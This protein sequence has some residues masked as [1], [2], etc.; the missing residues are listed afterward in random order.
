MQRSEDIRNRRRI[1]ALAV[2]LF[3]PVLIACLTCIPAAAADPVCSVLPGGQAAAWVLADFDGDHKLDMAV[4]ELPGP[5]DSGIL[6]HITIHSGEAGPIP[7]CATG[8]TER[9]S[10]RD[11]DGDSDRD[12]VLE[13]ASAEPIAIWINDG[14][15]HFQRAEVADFRYQ[16]SHDDP[17]SLDSAAR[18]SPQPDTVDHSRTDLGAVVRAFDLHL[19]VAGLFGKRD[20]NRPAEFQFRI[21]SRGPPASV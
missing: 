9:L 5:N 3:W 18:P 6:R 4:A 16:L 7:L 20:R 2:C 17:R 12:L 13:T 1:R 11:L 14:A 10:A 21:H 8:A 19:A 15:G